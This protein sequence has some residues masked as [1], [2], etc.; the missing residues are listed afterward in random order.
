MLDFGQFRL[1]PPGRSRNWPKSKSTFC[2]LCACFISVALVHIFID[3]RAVVVRCCVH[4]TR[5]YPELSGERT[6]MQVVLA[7]EIGGRF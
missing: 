2:C 5:T 7:G 6:P 1:R 4:K 3:C